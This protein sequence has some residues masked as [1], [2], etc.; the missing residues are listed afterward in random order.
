MPPKKR[1]KTFSARTPL[2][3]LIDLIAEIEIERYVQEIE[4]GKGNEENAGHTSGDLR[5]L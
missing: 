4:D 3:R 2:D 1:Q 5:P